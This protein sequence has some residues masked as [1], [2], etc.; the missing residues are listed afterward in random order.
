MIKLYQ[1]FAW[2]IFTPLSYFLWSDLVN[3]DVAKMIC[4]LPILW[5]YILPGIGTNYFKVW[6][7][8]LK[9]KIGNFKF[10][11]GFVFG[12]ATALL[13]AIIYHVVIKVMKLDDWIFIYLGSLIMTMINVYYDYIAV[14][15][16]IIFVYNKPWASNNGAWN[17]TKDYAIHIFGV[18]FILYFHLIL[19]IINKNLKIEND[20]LLFLGYLLILLLSPIMVF[21][22]HS[23]IKHNIWGFYPVKANN[24]EVKTLKEYLEANNE[25]NN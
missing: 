1:Y 14:K 11:H 6:E 23:K 13:T 18:F 5:A 20:Y 3:S 12:S 8:N 22:I 15:K 9:G 25:N 4:L 2:I 19:I 21:S 17:I 10:Q 24:K 16:K 7:F